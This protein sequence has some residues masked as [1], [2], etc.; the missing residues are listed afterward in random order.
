MSTHGPRHRR[1]RRDRARVRPSARRARARP[2]A[3]RP[4]PRPPRE[5]RRRAAGRSTPCRPEVL[6]AD[7]SDR[8]TPAE[9]AERLARPGA[10]GR[11]ARQQRRLRAQEALPATTTSP[12]EEAAFDV[13]ARAVLVLSHAAAR[14]MRERGHG[15]HRQ[16]LVGGRLHRL[17]HL[18]RR[19]GLRHGVH[20]G[21]RERA[22]RHRRHGDGPAAPASPTPSSTQRAGIEH[23]QPAAVHVAGPRRAW[24]SDCL[25][26]VAQ[27]RVVSVPGAQYKAIVGP[28]ARAAALTGAQPGPH[29]P[30][31]KGLSPG[32]RG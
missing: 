29:R 5:R 30:P 27:G 6:V 20:R 8:P 2:R 31:P 3:R 18:L 4:R 1:H 10:P 9:V 19:Q 22:R 12:I 15:R 14:A 16:R 26:D 13:L 25:D 17:R 7:L 32:R 24:C 21:A 28:A 11:P 23:V